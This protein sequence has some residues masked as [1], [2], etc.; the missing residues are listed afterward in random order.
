[1]ISRRIEKFMMY[2]MNI[3]MITWVTFPQYEVYFRGSLITL[4]LFCITLSVVGQVM[5]WNF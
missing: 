2:F 4:G 3:T 1:M 5:K